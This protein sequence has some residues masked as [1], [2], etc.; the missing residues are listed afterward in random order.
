MA[1]DLIKSRIDVQLGAS[2]LID[3]YLFNEFEPRL[4]QHDRNV[5]VVG[6]LRAPFKTSIGRRNVVNRFE[7]S[8]V[9]QHAGHTIALYWAMALQ[10]S[11]QTAAADCVIQIIAAPG[12]QTEIEAGPWPKYHLILH[13]ATIISAP[14]RAENMFTYHNVTIIGGEMETVTAP[15]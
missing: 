14:G 3:W 12:T 1:T 10:Q 13:D 2:H 11:W 5:Q 4:P 8:R 6:A 7:F 15:S 9:E